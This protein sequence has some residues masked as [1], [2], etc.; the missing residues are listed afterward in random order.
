[1]SDS[2]Y[3]YNAGLKLNMNFG[4]AGHGHQAAAGIHSWSVSAFAGASMRSGFVTPGIN[5]SS[6]YYSGTV[7][8][9]SSSPDLLTLVASPSL[10]FGWQNGTYRPLNTFN[11]FSGTGVYTNYKHSVSFGQ[12]LIL[13]LRHN[14]DRNQ[15]NSYFGLTLF[16]TFTAGHYNDVERG[17]FWW[18]D[19]RD[20]FWSAGLSAQLDYQGWSASYINDMYYGNN[21]NKD[22]YKKDVIFKGR[23]Y[24]RQ[25]DYD[26]R[27]NNSIE[28][29]SLSGPDHLGHRQKIS[30]GRTGRA[31]MWPSNLMHAH[32]PDRYDITKSFH[33]LWV[34]YPTQTIYS[35]GLDLERTGR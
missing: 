4:S 3:Q 28:Q 5:L 1:M 12:N 20:R 19:R 18:G 17:P 24:A 22:D 11:H 34:T 8:T 6:T 16:D 2:R 31:A 14:D 26:L 25:S 23:N 13:S 32:I 9:S 7:G 29:I 30:I 10:T 35:L 33:R 15:R 27:L 21:N